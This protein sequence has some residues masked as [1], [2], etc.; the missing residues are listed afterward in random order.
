M[1]AS[2]RSQPQSPLTVI[3]SPHFDDAVL[4]LGGVL[5]QRVNETIVV[6]IF[7]GN[8]A[9]AQ[10]AEGW[11]AAAGFGNSD[12]EITTRTME[13]A[14]ALCRYGA[15]AHDLSYLDFPY[16]D[17]SD[18]ALLPLRIAQDIT[19]I[20]E[21]HSLR[22]VFLYG[23]A[24][25]PL[26]HAHPDHRIV[27]DAFLVAARHLSPNVRSC[28]YEDLPY[29]SFG[30]A[31]RKDYRV[32]LETTDRVVVHERPVQ[33]TARQLSEKLEGIRD[34]AS[35]IHT[36]EAAGCDFL[37]IAER[38]ARSRCERPSTKVCACEV[39]YELESTQ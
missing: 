7:G 38:F 33:L 35:Q 27:H 37:E 12:M 19:A 26:S 21:P 4:S 30:P 14:R 23:P 34:Y 31:T 15:R 25:L 24:A 2:T 5:S 8:P 1:K 10:L 16:R 36:S 32:L 29:A 13:N 28:F 22:R 39:L 18:D 20:L 6:T 17:K 3:L 9:P 11:A